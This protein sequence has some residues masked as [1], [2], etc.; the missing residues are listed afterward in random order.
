MAG[1]QF[2]PDDKPSF[3]PFDLPTICDGTDSPERDCCDPC[4][5]WIFCLR[6]SLYELT[7][8]G[9]ELEAWLAGH[10]LSSNSQYTADQAALTFSDG[11]GGETLI[12]DGVYLAEP[13][14]PQGQHAPCPLPEREDDCTHTHRIRA[15]RTI[16]T[17]SLE[18]DEVKRFGLNVKTE[19]VVV[20]DVKYLKFT[21]NLVWQGAKN[22]AVYEPAHDPQIGD[23]PS[24]EFC[25]P[26]EETPY[27][28]EA[29]SDWFCCPILISDLI[30]VASITS[31]A[32]LD[33][34]TL[35]P[36]PPA[37]ATFS[38]FYG[39][40]VYET[41]DSQLCLQTSGTWVCCLG[42]LLT[43]CESGAPAC[44]YFEINECDAT[45]DGA[46]ADLN[47]SQDPLTTGEILGCTSYVY[48]GGCGTPGSVT[49][50]GSVCISGP[51]EYVDDGVYKLKV[52]DGKCR[53]PENCGSCVPDPAKPLAR[54]P[55]EVSIGVSPEGAGCSKTLT[56]IYPDCITPVAVYWPSIGLTGETVAY[57]LRNI[58]PES[59]TDRRETITMVLVDDR[60][61]VYCASTELTCGC[62]EGVSGHL[63][64]TPLPDGCGAQLTASTTGNCDPEDENPPPPLIEVQFLNGDCDLYPEPCPCGP[65][66]PD[67]PDYD[68]TG[69]F[70]CSFIMKDGDVAEITN[71]WTE[72]RW[73]VWDRACGCF[74][75]W[76]YVQNP[77]CDLLGLIDG[78][79]GF[80]D[81]YGEVV[82][83]SCDECPGGTFVRGN[84]EDHHW[85]A[86]WPAWKCGQRISMRWASTS[87]GSNPSGCVEGTIINPTD[88][89]EDQIAFYE[90]DDEG[91]FRGC[92]ANWSIAIYLRYGSCEGAPYECPVWCSTFLEYSCYGDNTSNPDRCDDDFGLSEGE[93]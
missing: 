34:V 50:T 3:N 47:P 18:G 79:P 74:G 24:S 26:K 57:T 41:G 51:V 10:W 86:Y 2:N 69:C 12:F 88:P 7:L 52:I 56:A 36:L 53:I 16:F 1:A 30:P 32:D 14:S 11:G 19:C 76:T 71:L 22:N 42:V 80:S 75:P 29:G 70:S 15:E 38:T 31:L 67:S 73:R 85:S 33:N 91:I 25:P 64:V 82:G 92:R 39:V 61:C 55:V 60:G 13:P 78:A 6:R 35:N 9:F 45:I 89:L 77:L 27:E 49:C 66:D 20:E 54:V 58:D 72:L 83:G 65:L 63:D 44:V 23:P 5:D 87:G 90:W 68:P 81:T 21:V 48:N 59:I 93:Q 37:T 84:T 40:Y 43:S 28:P 62:C 4:S 17:A 8:A 46:P